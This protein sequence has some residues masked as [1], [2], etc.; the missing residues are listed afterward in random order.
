MTIRGVKYPSIVAAA[1]ALNIA[2]TT[3]SKWADNG[4]KPLPYRRAV[5][6]EGVTY[7]SGA[8]AA[9]ANNTTPQTIINWIDKGKAHYV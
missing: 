6:V 3:A 5:I 4:G 1:R 2:E 7:P 9:K 8:A